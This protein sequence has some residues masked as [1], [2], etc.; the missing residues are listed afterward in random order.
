MKSL[1]L[2]Q[3]KYIIVVQEWCFIQQTLSSLGGG[4]MEELIKDE[5]YRF[6]FE[7]SY[8]AIFLTYPDGSICRANPSACEVFQ[9]SEEELRQIGRFGIVDCDD[10]RYEKALEERECK[11]KVRTELNFRKKD[12]TV[13]PA[14]CSSSVFKDAEGSM[15]TVDIIHDMSAFK[16]AEEELWREQEKTRYYASY[17]YLT[18]TYNRRA[19]MDHLQQEIDRSKREKTMTGLILL[20]IDYFK[21]INDSMGHNAGD[22]VLKKVALSLAEKLRPYDILGRY[23]GDEFII[24]LPNTTEA[25]IR[26]IAERLRLYVENSPVQWENES[27]PVTISLGMIC[28]ADTSDENA[29]SLIVKAD[30]NLY[31]A[32]QQRNIVYG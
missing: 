13:F 17:D 3:N 27:I 29:E 21:K 20:D 1:Y 5:I 30:K 11:G 6:L 25:E 26:N 7:N 14:E 24:C 31:L 12:G 28:S 16:Q 15:W 4:L 8:D 10:P 32:K 9:R 22:E 2:Q 23:G 18:A 19:F